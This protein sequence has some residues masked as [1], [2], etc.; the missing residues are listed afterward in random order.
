MSPP[1]NPGAENFNKLMNL[2][3]RLNQVEENHI[4]HELRGKH[5]TSAYR[6]SQQALRRAGTAVRR[7]SAQREINRMRNDV[8]RYHS[9][10]REMVARRNN[11]RRQISEIIGPNG[12]LN[13]MAL[14]EQNNKL[15]G[16][17]RVQGKRLAQL[18]ENMYL[19]GSGLYMKK[20]LARMNK[21]K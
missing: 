20:Q 12:Y 3:R 6:A 15:A 19:R 9:R 7:A 18:I 5:I 4:L 21:N 14:I 1:R 10:N 13:M 16:I 17:R 11:L 2:K 8:N